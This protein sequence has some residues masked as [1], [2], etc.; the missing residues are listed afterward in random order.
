M[1]LTD[2]KAFLM[3]GWGQFANQ[4]ILII[5]LLIFHGGNGNPPYSTVGTEQS[6]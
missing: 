5:S 2:I 1:L 4:V 3:Q 6:R